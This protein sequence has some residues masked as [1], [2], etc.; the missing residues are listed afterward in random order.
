MDAS[1]KQNLLPSRAA[2]SL[3]LIGL[4]GA[5]LALMILAASVLLRL[6]TVFDPAGRAVS[7]LPLAVENALR[8]LHRLAAAGIGLLALLATVLCWLRRKQLPA[9]LMPTALIVSTTVLL[10]LIGPLTPGY[11]LVWV[12]VSNV[13][14]GV[15]L[16]MACWWLRESMS[17]VSVQAR[18]R[19][20]LLPAAFIVLLA[21]I[22]SGAA[23]S[24][25]QM[26]AVVW[27]AFVHIGSA[28][29]VLV[30]VGAILWARQG[31]AWLQ[32]PVAC[33][34][35]LL[36]VQFALG[37]ALMSFDLRPVW[38]GFVHAMLTPLLAAGLVTVAVRDAATG[39]TR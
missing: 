11:R 9:A 1:I 13:L 19:D 36:I 29:L 26:H 3:R 23:A 34:T 6:S 18:A 37:L 32:R 24:A 7:I 38:L 17:V 5:V 21:H 20:P 27:G 30:F 35:L 25:Q 33:M 39:L 28:L 15:L 31:R 2:R 12:T 8:L 10:A 16:L 14:G 22:G 4:V